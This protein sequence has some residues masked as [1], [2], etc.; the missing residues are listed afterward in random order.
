M[1]GTATTLHL[2][3]FL[4][5]LKK[6][7]PKAKV[8]QSTQSL[9][10]LG[11]NFLDKQELKRELANVRD[12]G[13]R[14]SDQVNQMRPSLRFSVL[15]LLSSNK[16]NIFNKGL[17]DFMEM[18]NNGGWNSN[19]VTADFGAF[20]IDHINLFKELDYK[21]DS[22]KKIEELF[23]KLAADDVIIDDFKRVQ[24]ANDSIRQRRVLVTPTLFHYTVAREEESNKV[25]RQFKSHL[26]QFI[27]LSFVK[28]DYD[29]GFYCHESSRYLLGYIHSILSH[30]FYTGR[31]LKNNFLSYSNSQLKNH[32]C[33]YLSNMADGVNEKEIIESMGN[34][35]KEKNIL[36]R[37]ARRGQCFSTTKK[38]QTMRREEVNMKY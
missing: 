9:E 23:R 26:T 5:T 14:F 15:A 4:S 11:I 32:T 19:D 16:F 2:E 34:F 35:E 13:L 25:I 33:W 30:G 18:L 1:G 3:T 24:Q 22:S 31:F 12:K 29:Q 36:K 38:F 8:I 21:D 7:N 10:D 28:E 17:I 27:R 20:I 37:Y 6:L